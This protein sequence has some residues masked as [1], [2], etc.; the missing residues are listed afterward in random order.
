MEVLKQKQGLLIE[1][2]DSRDTPYEH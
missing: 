2:F 1:L